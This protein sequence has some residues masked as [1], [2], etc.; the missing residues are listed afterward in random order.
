[1]EEHRSKI[2][3]YGGVM[4]KMGLTPVAARVYVYLLFGA[5]PGATFD[6]LV[7]YFKVSKS[8]VSNAL[9][10]LETTGMADSKTFGGQRKRYFFINFKN[11]FNE[12]F[13]AARFRIVSDMLEDIKS[14]RNIDDAFAKELEEASLLYRMLLVEIPIILERWKRTLELDNKKT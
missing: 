8:A 2:E 13:M 7:T 11:T 9:K 3:H 10:T 12:E 5:G 6:E 4:E 1:M 14:T